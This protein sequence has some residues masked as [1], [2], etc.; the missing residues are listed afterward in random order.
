MAQPVQTQKKK[1]VLREDGRLQIRVFHQQRRGKKLPIH[2]FKCGCCD[3]NLKVCYD[4]GDLEINGVN[5]SIENWREVLLP[6]LQIKQTEAGF[7]ELNP[8]FDLRKKYKNVG[9]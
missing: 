6:L 4:T 5:A 3:E 8:L 2:T 9:R 7:E 1:G